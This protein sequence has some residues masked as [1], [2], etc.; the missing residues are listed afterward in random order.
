MVAKADVAR[1]LGSFGSAVTGSI[2]DKD[3]MDVD[4]YV[5]NKAMGE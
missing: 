3:S 2:L 1:S 4:A 5:T